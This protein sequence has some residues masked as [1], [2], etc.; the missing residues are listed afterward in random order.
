MASS[1]GSNPPLFR[2]VATSTKQIYQLLKCISFSPKVDVLLTHKGIQFRAD[3]SRV[4]QGTAF[5]DRALF[6]AYSLNVDED[7]ETMPQFQMNLAALLE[8]LQIFGVADV[9]TRA[10][11]TDADPYRSNIHNYRPD[12]FS[13]Q[14]L[15]MPGTCCLTYEEDG[16][17]LT[18]QLEESGVKTQCNMV[19][20][21][22]DS[23]DDIPFDKLA[24]HFKMIM[25]SRWLLDSLSELAPMAPARIT[26]SASPNAPYLKLSGNGAIGSASVNFS[27][28]RD[29]LET[30]TVFRPWAQ[31]FKF[32]LMKSASEAMRIASKASVRG[33][34]Q[35]VLSLQF[36]VEIEGGTV[37]FLDFRFVPYITQEDEET[38]SESGE[39]G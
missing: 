9:A 34:G 27:H 28:G 1:V 19:T 18:V 15:D 3:H 22:P 4:M 11:K 10:A 16:S 8:A 36:M 32:D 29:L 37:G 20:Y 26:L 12:A 14:T 23:P 35:G 25:Q 30:L 6:T 38:D 2:A 5:L 24:I 21:T 17:P 39:E 33:D 31:S 7:A 13:H